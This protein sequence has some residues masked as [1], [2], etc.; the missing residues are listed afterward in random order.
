[1]HFSCLLL[2]LVSVC[3]H[4]LSNFVTERTGGQKAILGV[5][6]PGILGKSLTTAWAPPPQPRSHTCPPRPSPPHAHPPPPPPRPQQLL[7][8]SRSSHFNQRGQGWNRGFAPI[9]SIYTPLD[10]L[11]IILIT[12]M[13]G[14]LVPFVLRIGLCL[15]FWKTGKILISSSHHRTFY[16]FIFF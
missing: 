12:R 9:M 10:T 15:Q 14:Y 5:R 7:P 13:W 4:Y 2:L 16:L 11:L 3:D 1:M 8:P 6:Y